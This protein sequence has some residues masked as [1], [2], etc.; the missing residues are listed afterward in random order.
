MDAR[1]PRSYVKRGIEEKLSYVI[2]DMT[3]FQ[4][5]FKTQYGI[6]LNDDQMVVK[7]IAPVALVAHI[8][9]TMRTTTHKN[10]SI[11]RPMVRQRIEVYNGE[12][13]QGNATMYFMKT[14]AEHY[15]AATGSY[16]G[17]SFANDIPTSYEGNALNTVQG[18]EIFNKE[19]KQSAFVFHEV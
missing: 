19:C 4:D 5:L 9:A 16:V 10:H 15:D 7:D 14:N 2:K 1:M 13:N 17:I 18:S 6:Y 12:L 11:T 3:M 8:Q